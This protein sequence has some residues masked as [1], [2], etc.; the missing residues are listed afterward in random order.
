MGEKERERERE[1]EERRRG[2][3]TRG[4]W[5]GAKKGMR[6]SLVLPTVT[7]TPIQRKRKIRD[8]YLEET[9]FMI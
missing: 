6:S 8:L 3:E 9:I 7:V 1:R 2:V 4:R 5:E